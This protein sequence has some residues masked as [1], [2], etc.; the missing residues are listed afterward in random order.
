MKQVKCAIIGYGGIARA[1]LAG[2]KILQAENQPVRLVAVCDVDPSKFSG[3]LSIN[4]KTEKNALPADVHTYTS[5][6]ELLANEEFDMADICLPTYLHKEYAIRLMRQGKHVLCEKP[7]ALSYADCEEMICVQEETGKRFMIG[8]CLRFNAAYLY[9]KGLVDSGEFGK[10]KHLF[11]ERISAQPQWG[12]EK[13]FTDT[14]RSGGCILDMHIHDIDMA[15]FL[16]GEPKAVSTWAIDDVVKW[17]VENTRLYYDDVMVV[18]NGSWG[19][20]ATTKFKSSYRARF[21][22]A[23]VVCEKDSVTVYPQEGEPF[24][25]ELP[26]TNHMAEEIRFLAGL[27]LDPDAKNVTNPP[28]SAAKTVELIEK[29]HLSAGEQGA[30]IKL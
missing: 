9:L 23:T 28:E 26:S 1:H 13:W 16:F 19:E 14:D 7:M 11:M 10:A 29:L 20:S 24:T 8:Q 6:D 17:A 22:R 3:Q 5:V 27:I 12:Y 15:R 18:I 25:P 2:Y 4:I 21:E 30:I